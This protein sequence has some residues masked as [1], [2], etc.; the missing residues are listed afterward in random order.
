MNLTARKALSLSLTLI[1]CCLPATTAA[2]RALV[3]APDDAERLAGMILKLSKLGRPAVELRVPKEPMYVGSY[4]R[5]PVV[6]HKKLRLKFDDLRFGVAE[7]P[8]GGT[9][10]ESRDET[11]RADAP[12]T[13]LIAGHKPG[14]YTLVATTAASGVPV[15]KAEFEV[16]VNSPG[17][18][19]PSFVVN[20]ASSFPQAA[21]AWGGGPGGL[22]NIDINR[23]V[24][25]RRVAMIFVDTNEQRFPT[26]AATLDDIRL[27]WRQNIAEGF[28][29]GG[30]SRS[31]LRYFKE[32]S[33]NLFD[34]TLQTFGPYQMNG[35]WNQVGGGA[36]IGGHVQAALTAADADI[37]YNQF[38]S[39]IVVSQSV[40]APGTPGRKA[41]WPR[42]S[43]GPWGWTTAEGTRS[44][45]ATQMP[46]DWKEQDGREI[47][48]TAA[49]E[50]GHNILGLSDLYTPAVAGRNVGHWD[51][52]DS[53]TNL[54]NFSLA[55]KMR[56]GWVDEAWVKGFNFATLGS[57][58]D[59]TVQLVPASGGDPGA[60][61]FVGAEVRVTD[62]LN[63]YFE[64]RKDNT[65]QI[66][67]AALPTNSRVFGTDVRSG[68]FVA[69]IQ[70]PEVILLTN[71]SDG[72]GPVLDSGKDYRETDNTSPIFPVEFRAEASGIDGAKADLRI[73]YGV[74]SK[75]D[76]SIRPWGAPPWQTP[77]I[78]VRNARNMTDPAWFNVPWAANNNTVVAKVKNGGLLD[79]PGVRAEFFVKDY[80]VGGAPESPLGSDTKDIPAGGT[81]EFTTPWVPPAEGHFCIIVRIPLY[82]RPGTPV[83]PEMTELNNSA[84]SNYDRFISATAS[85]AERRITHVTVGNPYD[86]ATR[87]YVGVQQTDP[88]YRTYLEH[89][90]LDLGP[91]ETRRVTVMFEYAGAPVGATADGPREGP[92]AAGLAPLVGLGSGFSLPGPAQ[93]VHDKPPVNRVNLVGYA[94]N[95][96]DKNRHQLVTLGGAGVEVATG[97]AVKFADFGVRDGIV[98]GKVTTGD[99]QPVTGGQIIVTLIDG[100][101]PKARLFNRWARPKAGAFRVCCAQG[102]KVRAYYLPPPGFGDATSPTV[103]V[104]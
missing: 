58:V 32:A 73:R 44:L 11:F 72:D 88:Q 93:Q 54:P 63:Y 19:G 36:D 34:F 59:Q 39:V 75:P 46:V 1:L 33:H 78:E 16:T 97:R 29:S 92:Q 3:N 47:Y 10:S 13:M 8:Q 49:H 94:V 100:E 6:I 15:A 5:V 90:W 77:D 95:P 96:F 80:T 40:G 89:K 104:K 103:A 48:A 31:T 64:Y 52:M 53:E 9:V 23:T 27:R 24:G 101:G 62:G 30:V 61:K 70:R 43:V 66:A 22:Q 12:E 82:V 37:D 85:P 84:Q 74:N 99:G 68:S 87:V 98:E 79:A 35:D 51:L 26:D 60:G 18:V 17:A 7:G 38:D 14:K 28:T 81:V 83:V 102:M 20:G 86:K 76:P 50:F 42:S 25:T 57:P 2:A 55:Y 41:V 71:D 56:L 65:A 45:G 69:P 21:S 91:H 4:A 67:D